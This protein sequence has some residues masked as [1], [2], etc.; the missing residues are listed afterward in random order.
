VLSSG[1][2]VGVGYYNYDSATTQ[3]F[4]VD[5][6]SVNYSNIAPYTVP[7]TAEGELDPAYI[8]TPGEM[9]TGP[10]SSVIQE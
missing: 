4:L 9:T 7:L 2:Y 3:P 1:G 8:V 6:A 10:R 5:Y